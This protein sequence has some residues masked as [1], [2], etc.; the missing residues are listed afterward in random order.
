M[1]L[2]TFTSGVNT[3]FSTELNENFLGAGMVKLVLDSTD[4]SSLY[5]STYR[6]GSSEGAGTTTATSTLELDAI[7][8]SS[9]GSANYIRIT[10]NAYCYAYV[11]STNNAG[12]A[13]VNYKIETKDVGGSYA[14]SLP[15]YTIYSL[16]HDSDQGLWLT[17]TAN[18]VVSWLHTLT[19]D[20]KTN[21]ISIQLT[22][23]CSSYVNG[24]FVIARTTMSAKQIVVETV[25]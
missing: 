10:L 18:V 12:T 7:A 24:G 25:N 3:S 23:Q 1:T 13:T 9:I 2:N 19:N 8:A 16:S 11:N 5:T 20:E 22:S 6:N 4:A 21:G 14:E 15:L 17:N